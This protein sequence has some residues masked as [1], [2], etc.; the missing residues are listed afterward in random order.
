MKD[1]PTGI[2]NTIL[3]TILIVVCWNEIKLL[4][5]WFLSIL[6]EKEL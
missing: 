1:E 6:N 3:W 4:K 5:I 2:Y